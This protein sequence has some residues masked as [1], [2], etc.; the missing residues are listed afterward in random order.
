MK[1]IILTKCLPGSGKSTWALDFLK[2]NPDYKRIN[3]DELRA[4]IDG[5]KWTHKNEKVILNMREAGDMRKDSIVKKEL[6]DQHIR[7]KYNV[8]MVIDDRDQVVD[9]W[10][11]ELG[12]TCLQVAEG[13]F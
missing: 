3:K 2:K 7:G 13:D 5:G 11:N 12:L 6:F 8:R 1:K 9:M 4:M 10:R